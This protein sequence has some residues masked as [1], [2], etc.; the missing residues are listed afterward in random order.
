MRKTA[1]AAPGR[2]FLAKLLVFPVPEILGLAAVLAAAAFPSI[3]GDLLSWDDVRYVT[4]NEL[5]RSFGNSPSVFTHV[6]FEAYHPLHI[7]SIMVDYALWGLWAPGYHVHTL[8][9]YLAGLV[10]LNRFLAR[11]GV[12]R[13]WSFLLTVL[14]ALHPLHVEPAAWVTGRKE[15]LCFLLFMAGAD[16]YMR[17]DTWRS[18]RGLLV[19]ALFML[20][21]LSKS[22][23]VVFPF[24]L[25]GID[26]FLKKKGWKESLL[27]MLPLV[28]FVVVFSVLVYALWQENELARPRPASLAAHA[29]LILDAYFFYLKKLFLPWPLSPVYPIPLRPA[30]HV[31]TAAMLV[32]FAIFAWLAWRFKNG[33]ARF[34]L[35][36]FVFSLLPVSNIVPVYFFVA[37]RYAFWTVMSL[38]FLLLAVR[39]IPAVRGRRIRS[40]ILAAAVASVAA[41][42]GVLFSSYSAK[43]RGDVT[44]WEHAA[45]VMPESYYAHLKLGE[46]YRDGGRLAEAGSQYR[47]AA[48]IEPGLRYAWVALCWSEAKRFAGKS[49]RPKDEWWTLL[50]A[51][52]AWWND[53][54]SLVGLKDRMLSRGYLACGEIAENRAFALSPPGEKALILSASVWL[55]AGDPARALDHLGRVKPSL[56]E[57]VLSFY[58]TKAAAHLALGQ[59]DEAKE[60]LDAA[61]AVEGGIGRMDVGEF[62]EQLGARIDAMPSEK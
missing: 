8:L 44:L 12:E 52:M 43:W 11:A 26:L 2:G 36:W 3:G 41:V 19:V 40:W 6:M 50:K 47:K 20:S 62:I 38:V 27:R 18:P 45:A 21:L 29:A 14:F 17:L 53:P 34:G 33:W 37:D 9:L 54:A 35:F 51:L 30:W 15:V 56:P 55:Q 48:S 57:S 25:L 58:L 22:H 39:D 10:F 23:A 4:R 16:Q 42:F 31:S 1:S 60:A 46:V 32:L 59:K 24:F 7:V 61:R 49:G 13:R 5:I 28:L